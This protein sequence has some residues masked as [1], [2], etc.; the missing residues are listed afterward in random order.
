MQKKAQSSLEFLIIFGI[1]FIMIIAL[2]GVFFSYSSEAKLSLDK[3]QLEKIGG[4]L[5]SN[6]EKIYFN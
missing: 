3:T 6:I 1:G 5:I 4:E 2:S